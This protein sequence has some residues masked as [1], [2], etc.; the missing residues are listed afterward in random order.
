MIGSG[1]AIVIF[2]VILKLILLIELLVIFLAVKSSL[3][4]YRSEKEVSKRDS[5]CSDRVRGI[6]FELG[7][8]PKPLSTTEVNNKMQDESTYNFKTIITKLYPESETLSNNTINPETRRYLRP[9]LKATTEKSIFK[10]LNE[11]KEL[12]IELSTLRKRHESIIH[13]E[14]NTPH[15]KNELIEIE[16][17]INAAKSNLS[18]T[19]KRLN[20]T[21]RRGRRYSLSF[22][23]FL[24]YLY[25]EFKSSRRDIR[26]IH[27]VISN[28]III[29]EAPFLL[30]WMDFEKAGFHVVDI[31]LKISIELRSQLHIDGE[32]DNYLL[33]RTTE[34]YFIEVSNYFYDLD[35][36]FLIP[37]IS[38]SVPENMRAKGLNE[39]RLMHKKITHYRKEMLDLQRIWIRRQLDDLNLL[40]VKYNKKYQM[41]QGQKSSDDS[42]NQYNQ[43]VL[44]DAIIENPKAY[45]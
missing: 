5:L 22:R 8:S 27:A 25:N 7:R 23:G 26:R 20:S 24:L 34:R 44:T 9:V 42:N 37:I 15:S 39:Y 4:A 14:L 11:K 13:D 12:D 16:S 3:K 19:E 21:V 32:Y 45:P 36:T 31:L 38:P 10:I 40:Y 2:A 6:L 28:P 17:K 41:L 33:R 35:I 18:K 43:K 29:S 1:K 30:Y